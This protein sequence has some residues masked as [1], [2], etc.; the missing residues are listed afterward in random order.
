MATEP[1]EAPMNPAA[2][3][4]PPPHPAPNVA[5]AL[6]PPPAVVASR[7]KGLFAPTYL[8]LVSI[9]QGVALAS[10]AGK[11][12][13]GYPLFDGVAWVLVAAT[14]I[15]YVIVWIEFVQAVATYVWFPNLSDAVTPFAVA[16]LEL[17][18]AHFAVR[19]TA[20]LRGYLLV[21]A[22]IYLVGALGFVQIAL[23]VCSPRAEADNRDVH[24]ALAR[25][26]AVRIG[27]NV[28]TAILIFAAWAAYEA[29][30]LGRRALIVAL[31]LA[32]LSVAYLLN[33]VPYWNRVLAYASLGEKRG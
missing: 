25:T 12:E 32:V 33:S 4:A 6:Q 13:D 28:A 26:R 10:L 24:H 27:H 9:I 15:T 5:P 31:G 18:Q 17:F 11:S 21:N 2:T 14:L 20:G 7:L 16:A 8:T 3:S 23:R 29:A 30:G 1:R 22:V 19:G